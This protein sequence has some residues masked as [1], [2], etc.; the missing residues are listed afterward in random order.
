MKKLLAL[1]AVTMCFAASGW[2]RDAPESMLSWLSDEYRNWHCGHAEN[3][4]SQQC[5][6]GLLG[7]A[8]WTSIGAPRARRA[9][10][11][12]SKR[13][14]YEFVDI[15]GAT[16]ATPFNVCV[17]DIGMKNELGIDSWIARD[18]VGND[19]YDLVTGSTHILRKMLDLTL[20]DLGPDGI[21]A[22]AQDAC[23]R[24]QIR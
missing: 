16:E 13:D 20:D 9:G 17:F 18:L 23:S 19:G 12:L 3:K 7:H 2:Y 8:Y 1:I 24:D 5:Q 15:A 6:Y 10:W 14:F 21:F 11:Q 22:G 4:G